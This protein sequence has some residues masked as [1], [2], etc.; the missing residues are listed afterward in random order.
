MATKS[1][2]KKEVK[3][4][5]VKTALQFWNVSVGGDCQMEMFDF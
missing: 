2:E 5:T 3:K 1:T 4:N